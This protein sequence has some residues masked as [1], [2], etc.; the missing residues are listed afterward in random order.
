[1][2]PWR[3]TTALALAASTAATALI[4]PAVVSGPPLLAA[5]PNPRSFEGAEREPALLLPVGACAGFA[6]RPSLFASYPWA[7]V[8][9]PLGAPTAL[10]VRGTEGRDRLTGTPSH[11]TLE[12]LGGDD[13]LKGLGG[14]DLIDGG[15]GRDTIRAGAGNDLIVAEGDGARD[16]VGCGSGIDTVT[17]DLVDAVAADCETVSRE[18]SHDPF[19]GFDAQHQTEAEPDSFAYGSAMV[20]VFQVARAA[21]GGGAAV[22]GFATSRDGGYT[23][24]AGLLP[25][26]TINSHP[27]GRYERATDPSVAYDVQHRVWLAASLVLD[28]AGTGVV[29]SRSADGLAWRAPVVAVPDGPE[30]PDKEWIVCDNWPASPLR[31]TCYLAYLDVAAGGIA[32]R[33]SADGGGTWSLP[34]L[35]AARSISGAIVNGAQPAVLKNGTLVVL[36]SVFESNRPGVDQI[37]AVR[38]TNG[39]VT[40]TDPARV[41]PLMS[42]DVRGLRVPPF[43]SAE[44]DGG[45]RI[46]AAW[47][48]CRFTPDCDVD[49]IVLTS[50]ADGVSWTEPTRVP[51]LTGLAHVVPGLGVDPTTSGSTTRLAVISYAVPP[52]GGC[53]LGF[54]TCATADVVLASSATAGR[55]WR[56]PRRLDPRPM[57]LDWM[58][59][60][61]IGAFLGDYISLS[62]IGGRPVPVFALARPPVGGGL[63]QALYAGV[64]VVGFPGPTVSPR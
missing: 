34:V 4:A 18:L 62:W 14:A 50:S 23:W 29:V 11:D 53:G 42:E 8:S 13:I 41:S 20:A 52:D 10:P 5:C 49:D 15:A 26:L 37:G 33:S 30:S 48:D 38:S 25:S 19:G 57:R 35:T 64:R 22:N 1:V 59:D 40:F 45:G 61:E 3:T 56:Q 51:G 12:G 16:D 63:R 7:G 6:P 2:P 47:S 43:V 31:G 44:V 55:T 32:V 17:A 58:A 21:D 24:R 28:D 39:G 27:T 54:V 36:Y 60:G 9:V 46:W